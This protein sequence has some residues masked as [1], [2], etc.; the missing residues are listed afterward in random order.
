MYDHAAMNSLLLACARV[1]RVADA[2]EVFEDMRQLKIVPNHMT[3]SVLVKMYGRARMP[4]KAESVVEA[5]QHEFG[6]RPNLQVYTS[7]IQ[8]L[9]Q[10]K[11]WQRGLDIFSR[12]SRAGIEPDALT[13]ATIVQGCINLGMFDHAMNLVKNASVR[14]QPEVL[15][16][17]FEAMERK[18]CHSL[19]GELK[20][21]MR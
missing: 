16:N 13:L 2:E 17:L 18:G 6:V 12:M 9:S 15:H 10:N 3:T 14:F 20:V 11:L 7:L 21:F 8:A 4:D 5:I 1:D 19:A